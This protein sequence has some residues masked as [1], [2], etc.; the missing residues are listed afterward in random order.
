MFEYICDA[1]MYQQ[2]R[3][4][5]NKQLRADEPSSANPKGKHSMQ[6]DGLVPPVELNA[7]VRYAM[8]FEPLQPGLPPDCGVDLTS[9]LH[10]GAEPV[11][12]SPYRLSSLELEED[13]RQ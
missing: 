1:A 7:L 12:I 8:V 5:Q 2:R 6:S 9:P 11:P 4:F 10:S 3:T 13:E